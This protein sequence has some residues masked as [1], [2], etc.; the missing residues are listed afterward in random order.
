MA[1]SSKSRDPE[2][3][4]SSQVRVSFP[5]HV[6]PASRCDGYA[7]Q[8][9]T[10]G[11]KVFSRVIRVD[12]RPAVLEL[13]TFGTPV[14]SDSSRLFR[15]AQAEMKVTSLGV[16]IRT[17]GL[18]LL[19]YSVFAVL[20]ASLAAQTG[21]Q[22][23]E[24]AADLQRGQAALKANDQ[25][26][27]TKEFRA[28][29]KI[30]PANVEAHANLGVMAFFHGDCTDAEQ[31]FKSALSAAPKLTKAL[32]LMAICEKRQGKPAAQTDME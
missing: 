14:S 10:A 5:L 17:I 22:S 9:A 2:N 19:V 23:S 24:L 13:N 31:E 7:I 28:A 11:L 32:A 26:T 4:E 27:A 8:S 16:T 6:S 1:L 12:C 20:S 25:A 29:L 3:G 30:D 15:P 18:H 21:S